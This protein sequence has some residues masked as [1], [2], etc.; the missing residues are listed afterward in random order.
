MFIISEALIVMY[1][2]LH[3]SSMLRLG[4]I[5]KPRSYISI[6]YH[7]PPVVVYLFSTPPQTFLIEKT[8]D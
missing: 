6:N 5:R 3:Q 8:T 2:S 7:P 4:N 1:Q